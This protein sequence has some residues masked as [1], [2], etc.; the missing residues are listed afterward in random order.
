MGVIVGGTSRLSRSTVDP[1]A[2]FGRSEGALRYPAL[3][4]QTDRPLREQKKSYIN[5]ADAASESEGDTVK[6]AAPSGPFAFL[7]RSKPK[8]SEERAGVRRL[9]RRTI[10]TLD[11]MN[12]MIVEL[13]S[14]GDGQGQKRPPLP[15]CFQRKSP[16]PTKPQVDFMA[17]LKLS[18]GDSAAAKAEFERILFKRGGLNAAKAQTTGGEPSTEEA[19]APPVSLARKKELLLEKKAKKEAAAARK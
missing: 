1:R 13:K 16:S 17:L 15:D 3:G 11:E 14:K 5:Y 2:F 9:K 4:A 6:A 19:Q 12:K 7:S 10:K 8:E 18:F